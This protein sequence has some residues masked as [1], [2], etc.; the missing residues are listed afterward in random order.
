MFEY[1]QSCICVHLDTLRHIISECLC[2]HIM[3]LCVCMSVCAKM[4]IC[5]RREKKKHKPQLKEGSV[6]G[7]SN[8]CPKP[9]TL[10]QLR[11]Q[12]LIF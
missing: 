2:V 6:H 9:A 11:A 5:V 8:I 10:S 1:V 3:G 12:R 7:K 4:T